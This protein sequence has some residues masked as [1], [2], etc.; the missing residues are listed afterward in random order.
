MWKCVFFFHFYRYTNLQL[1]IESIKIFYENSYE[2]FV[3]KYFLSYFYKQ[4]TKTKYFKDILRK[5][6][7][8][9]QKYYTN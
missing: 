4:L 3:K 6:Q 8:N 7:L 1:Q 5:N 9:K 2:L